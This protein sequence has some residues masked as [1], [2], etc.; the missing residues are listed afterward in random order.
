MLHSFF[1]NRFSNYLDSVGMEIIHMKKIY[2]R[3]NEDVRMDSNIT[4]ETK[5][6]CSVR[7]LGLQF[8]W[9]YTN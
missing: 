3:H 1:V 8:R 5:C 7:Y 4:D 9:F 2:I 6:R